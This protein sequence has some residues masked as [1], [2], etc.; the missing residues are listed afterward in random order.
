MPL[1]KIKNIVFI[2]SGN[3]ATHLA[4]SFI[5]KGFVI[6]QVYSRNL[7]NA[8]I[9]AEKIN[10]LYTDSLTKVCADADLYIISITDNA[11][12]EMAA[13]LKIEKKIVVH[14]SGSVG[15]KVLE[16][17]ENHGVFYP[18]QT[19][20]KFS[21]PD[22]STIP[23]LI[24]ANNQNNADLLNQLANQLTTKVFNIYSD[25]R[26]QVHLAAVFA[27]NFTNY[28]YDIADKILEQSIIPFDILKPLIYETA[29]K[30]EQNQPSSVQTGPAIRKDQSTIEKHLALLSSM[31]DYKKIYKLLSENII[32][33]HK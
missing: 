14:T 9:L 13:Q 18:L 16:K 23:I 4:M 26:Q 22:F 25:Q 27:C 15:I 2:G 12:V 6:Q 10:S 17:F 28:M 33:E 3:V 20:S 19:F 31:P 5:Q 21:K 11:I 24:E 30:I 29:R 8:R 1:Q 7:Q 32:K